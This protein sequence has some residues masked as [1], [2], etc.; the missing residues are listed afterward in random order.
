[1]PEDVSVSIIG[2]DSSLC[3]FSLCRLKGGCGSPLEQA[4][5]LSTISVLYSFED[6]RLHMWRARNRTTS[7]KSMRDFLELASKKHEHKLVALE[8]AEDLPK[9]VTTIPI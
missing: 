4:T 5:G 7:D 2:N 3:A 8:T 9:E 1:M 6:L